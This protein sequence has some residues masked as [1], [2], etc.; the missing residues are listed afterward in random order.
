[1]SESI[2]RVGLIGAGAM[3]RPMA[4]NLLKKG[5]ETY[6]T[7][8]R[9][10][11]PIEELVALGAKEV[12]S[13]AEM[14]S[15]VEVIVTMVPDA[16]QVEETCFGPGGILESARPGLVLIDMST[17]S[18]VATRSIAARL[19]E[20]GVK[21]I[22]A[23]VSGG[24]WRAQS[25]TLTIMAGGDAGTFEQVKLVL[26]AFGSPV[27]VGETG[28]G[29]VVKLVNQIII[30]V[31]AI[32]LVEAFTFGVKAGAKAETL[33][34]VLMS[35]TSGS[36]L[37]DKWIPQNL[38]KNDFSAGFASELLNKDLNAALSAA[39]DL[40]VPMMST[41]LSQQLYATLKGMGYNREDYTAIARIYQEA[42]GVIIA[43]GELTNKD[44]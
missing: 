4:E 39:R 42:A 31:S 10:R 21:M 32:G 20:K 36:Y 13:A 14:A 3:G 28:M 16:P 19:A 34:E 7:A 17:I 41:A 11:Q 22:D 23:P 27:L 35:A 26:E 29:E 37:M 25:G 18:P 2:K 33:R 24:P 8:H 5:F 30:G 43:T 40:G 12:A 6:V 15:L 44:H 38:L 1:M 9:N